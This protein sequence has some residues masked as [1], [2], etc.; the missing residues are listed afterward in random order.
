M[1]EFTATQLDRLAAATFDRYK[2]ALA[3][4]FRE[5][6]PDAPAVQDS[7][8]LQQLVVRA[9]DQGYRRGLRSTQ[10]MASYVSL[11]V[12]LNENIDGMPE[13]DALF[14]FS[15]IDADAKVRLLAE[16]LIERLRGV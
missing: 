5:K 8:G 3:D 9:V 10:S 11:A 4:Y 12:L 16:A 7:D 15:G 2:R 6:F 13:I 14:G 1:L